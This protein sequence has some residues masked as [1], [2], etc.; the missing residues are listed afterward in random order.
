MIR[1]PPRSTLF[2]Y[3]TLFRSRT[4]AADRYRCCTPP[5]SCCPPAGLSWAHPNSCRKALTRKD[6]RLRLL[7][8]TLTAAE[9]DSD[10]DGDELRRAAAL[11]NAHIADFG[12]E[13]RR[14]GTKGR[15]APEIP[16]ELG[17]G[18]VDGST[19]ARG[20]DLQVVNA[21]ARE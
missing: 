8:G 19:W 12:E 9:H 4:T 1:R 2:P 14:P 15:T 3:T 11:L 17:L 21:A 18:R 13:A 6:G 5:R 10:G 7:L 16:R 20:L